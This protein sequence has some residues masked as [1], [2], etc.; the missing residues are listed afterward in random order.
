MTG[1]GHTD[2]S[3]L[4]FI[5]AARHYIG[6]YEFD[7]QEGRLTLHRI[8]VP[9]GYITAGREAMTYVTD[10]RNFHYGSTD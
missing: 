1:Y 8:S 6:P 7:E 2:I 10:H 9:W 5:Q 3:L 4:Y